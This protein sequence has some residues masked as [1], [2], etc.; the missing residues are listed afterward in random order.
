MHRRL[1]RQPLRGSDSTLLE[2]QL[3]NLLRRPFVQLD[4]QNAL[5]LL[6]LA[7]SEDRPKSVARQLEQYVERCA[8][9]LA[10]LPASGLTELLAEVEGIAHE[11]IPATFRG[12]IARE[13]ER[14]D[15]EAAP[16]RA[17]VERWAAT[18]PTPFV[19]GQ[20]HAKVQ[21]A[22]AAPPPVEPVRRGVGERATREPAAP[23]APAPPKLPAIGLD[24]ETR[25]LL[26][27]ICMERLN[28]AT[29][30]GLAETVL[31]AGVRHRAKADGHGEVSMA[32]V[33]AV[34]RGLKATNRVRFSAG[35]WMS[36]ARRW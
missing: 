16:L 3:Q 15:R 36:T 28:G 26:E 30:T 19:I 34:L 11:L 12:W 10:D 6:A 18:E 9:E 24:D 17:L 35:R 33:T 21:R 20:R 13:A 5:D 22:S 31:V 2:V 32:D 25:T 8:N 7:E 27:R 23:K 4:A 14:T 29:E 1:P